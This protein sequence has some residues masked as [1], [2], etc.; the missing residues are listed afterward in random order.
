[1]TLLSTTTLSGT[2]T[3]VSSISGSYN[4]LLVLINCG[5]D[6]AAGTITCTINGATTNY[7]INYLSGT[8]AGTTTS[9]IPINANSS[10]ND[11]GDGNPTSTAITIYDYA[12][13]SVFKK[14]EFAGLTY[15]VSTVSS[16]F[17][18]GAYKSTSAITSITVAT[19]G[20][21]FQA[22]CKIR[23]YGIK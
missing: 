20:G 12:N 2:T 21:T 14:I 22:D 3:T 16:I 10:Q 9:Q 13:T 23:I 15:L 17:G 19:T 18:G 6:N 11:T 5:L 4:T 8:T 1:M 7:N